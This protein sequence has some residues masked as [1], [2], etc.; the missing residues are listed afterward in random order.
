MT[1]TTVEPLTVRAANGDAYTISELISAL[2]LLLIFLPA[3]SQG[4]LLSGNHLSY[5]CFS[6]FSGL[7]SKKRLV[8]NRFSPAVG[9]GSLIFIQD[10]SKPKYTIKEIK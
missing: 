5:S 9:I 7:S 3:I 1:C 2:L 10:T 6:A 4:M 8:F